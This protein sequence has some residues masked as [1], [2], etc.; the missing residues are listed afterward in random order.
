M[1]GPTSGRPAD[2]G[3]DRPLVTPVAEPL[4]VAARSEATDP[5]KAMTLFVMIVATLYFGR[6]VLVPIALALLLA[7]LLT[8]LVTLLRRL[9][10][11]R[12]PAVLIGMVVALAM[13]LSIGAVIGAQIAQLST[14]LPRYVVTTET[15]IEAVRSFTVGRLARLADQIGSQR[16]KSMNQAAVA[17]A[18]APQPEAV[19]A[20]AASVWLPGD[21]TPLGLAQRFV[22]PVL[23]PL[24]T[25]GLVL[26][27][28]VF[29]LLQQDDLRDRLI[30]LLGA[31]DPEQTTLGLSDATHR[32]SRYFMSQLLVNTVFGIVIGLGLLIIGVPNPVLFGIL[33]ALLRFVPYIGSLIAALL[34]MTLSAAVDPGWSLVLWT[35]LLYL[36][37]ESLTGQIVEPLLYA[38]NTG[39]SPFTVVVAAIFWSWLWGTDRARPVDSADHVPCRD[40]PACR[41]AAVPRHPVGRTSAYDR[42]MTRASPPPVFDLLATATATAREPHRAQDAEGCGQEPRATTYVVLSTDK[43]FYLRNTLSQ[44]VAFRL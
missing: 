18:G 3:S 43:M 14:D 1:R 39:L 17:Q 35:A 31:G 37:V 27:V 21:A 34:P 9:H 33:S 15:K 44:I 24:V 42:D 40:R 8:P 2:S 19:P 38:H 10:L 7:F 25:L 36:V 23:S 11:G 26:I 41:T 5:A 16:G 12:V 22:S 29:A 28:A 32:L 30:H 13:L 20:S 4:P 6:D